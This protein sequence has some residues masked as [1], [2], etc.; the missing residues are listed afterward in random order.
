MDS[1]LAYIENFKNLVRNAML[2]AQKAHDFVFDNSCE[3]YVA[4]L[5]L[6]IADRKSVV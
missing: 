2:Y 3:N 1:D 4:G 5:Y 6:N